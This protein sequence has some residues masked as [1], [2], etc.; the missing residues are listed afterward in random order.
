MP[1]LIFA[2]QNFN[3]KVQFFT[4]SLNWHPLYF[5][6]GRLGLI[7]AAAEKILTPLGRGAACW[8]TGKEEWRGEGGRVQAAFDS[9]QPQP[10]HTYCLAHTRTDRRASTR[11]RAHTR[12]SS[13]SCLPVRLIHQAACLLTRRPNEQQLPLLFLLSLSL[14]LAALC[15]IHSL[16]HIR[17]ASND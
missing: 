17:K 7:I 14:S 1:L 2:S 16:Q 15:C 12:S 6:N 11:T 3:L 4:F 5:H 8:Y 13:Q 10:I 9:W